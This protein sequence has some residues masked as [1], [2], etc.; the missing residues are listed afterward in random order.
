MGKKEYRRDREKRRAV[1]AGRKLA[2]NPHKRLR[3]IVNI[4]KMFIAAPNDKALHQ[5]FSCLVRTEWFGRCL[6]DSPAVKPDKYFCCASCP[7]EMQDR[8]VKLCWGPD[9]VL[10]PPSEAMTVQALI[11]FVGLVKSLDA[12]KEETEMK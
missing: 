2:K 8:P 6:F 12:Y 3:K 7:L 11:E 10:T 5:R 1:R 9:H 4:A